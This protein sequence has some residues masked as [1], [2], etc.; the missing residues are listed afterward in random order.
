M[1]GD[2]QKGVWPPRDRPLSGLLRP[3]T[4]DDRLRAEV[5]DRARSDYHPALLIDN[6]SETGNDV[7]AELSGDE[8]YPPAEEAA[9][10][11]PDGFLFGHVGQIEEEYPVKSLGPRKL[12]R[13]L[14]DVVAGSHEEHVGF[15][16]GAMASAI[17]RAWRTFRSD[18]PTSELS[19][20]PTSSVSVG[21]P[22]SFPRALANCDLAQPS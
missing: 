20:P 18:S 5:P 8:L 19:K 17:R 6:E 3:D 1:T 16:V 9:V 13:E 7:D 11:G 4:L 12:R 21:R 2:P 22:T 10:H 15:V 14:G